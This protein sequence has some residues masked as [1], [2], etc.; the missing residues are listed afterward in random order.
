MVRRIGLFVFTIAAIVSV[1]TVKSQAQ[2]MLT[3]H[4][5]EVTRSGEVRPVGHL[6][7]EQIMHLDLVLPLRDQAGL[8]RFLSEV[9]DPTS[10][11]YRHYLTPTEFTARFGPTQQDYDAVVRFAQSHG[12]SVTG[13]TRDGMEDRKS[14]V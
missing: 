13:G 1:A 14:V 2:S 8:D 5:R 10:S 3:H 11:S 6:P 9:Y 7:S 12:L 4:M